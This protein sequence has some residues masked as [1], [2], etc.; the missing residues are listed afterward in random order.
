M[1]N[2]IKYSFRTEIWPILILLAAIGLSVWA[3][4][5]LPARVV[6]HWN[7]YGQADGWSSRE[8]HALFFPALLVVMYILF[9]LMPLFDPKSERY[10]E[11]S[12]VYLMMRNLILLVLGVVFTAATFSNLGF[13]VNIGAIVSGTIGLMMIILGNYFGKLK[14]NWF[15]GL[16]TPWTLSSENVWN[17][18][19]RFG[20]R[21]F[22]LWGLGLIIAPWLAPTLAFVIVIGGVVIMLA[23]IGIYSYALYKKEKRDGDKIGDNKDML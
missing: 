19:H 13:A 21:L 18:T 9:S 5:Q 14:R 6:T 10:Q 17:K 4:P 2:P 22:I 12:R 11:F 1:K 16:R 3:Y 15:V 23:G 7:F 8:F 20:G